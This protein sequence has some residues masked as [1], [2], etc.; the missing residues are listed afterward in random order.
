MRALLRAPRGT[1]TRFVVCAWLSAIVT[2]S[3]LPKAHQIGRVLCKIQGFRASFAASRQ[4]LAR[5][6]HPAAAVVA[7]RS[8]IEGRTSMALLGDQLRLKRAFHGSAVRH[9][10]SNVVR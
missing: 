4:S 3:R 9:W 10:C 2:P 6:L 5:H 7:T 1:W 8:I